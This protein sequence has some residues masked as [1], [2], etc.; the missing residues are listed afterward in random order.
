MLPIES[1][2]NIFTLHIKK[3]VSSRATYGTKAW[4]LSGFSVV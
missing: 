1:D 2:Q 4:S 3:K